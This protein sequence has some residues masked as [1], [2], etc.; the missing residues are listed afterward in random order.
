MLTA[1]RRTAF[2]SALLAANAILPS[3]T[4]AADKPKGFTVEES[5]S[6]VTVSYN[7]ELVT[8]YVVESESNKPFLWPVIGPTGKAVTRAY[9]MEDIKSEQQDHPHHRG[10]WFGH[11]HV[12]DSDTWHE[13]RTVDE[14]KK[15]DSEKEAWMARLGPTKHRKFKSV[16][17]DANSATII[18]IDDYLDSKGAKIMED[19]RVVRFRANGDQRVIDYDITFKATAG[20]VTFNDVKDAGFN[21]RVPSA[22]AVD[23]K[24]G[25]HILTSEGITDKEAWGTRAA[26]CSY[27][28]PLDGEVVGI[29]MLNH[30]SSFRH[31]T[32]WHVRTYGLLTANPF[33]THSLNPKAEDGTFVLKKGASMALRHRIILHKGDPKAA[34]IAGQ[35]E[36]YSK[37]KH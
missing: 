15:K 19:E 31:P 26:W 3:T 10:I 36:K 30:P 33:G 5:A 16:K 4:S 23:S 13:K 22:M 28:G 24:K 18:A 7:G 21:I 20:D 9:P 11:E 27:Y 29:T 17:A 2:L 6:G 8:K 14:T 35:F 25:G 34:D 32:P 1:I 37:E 12:N